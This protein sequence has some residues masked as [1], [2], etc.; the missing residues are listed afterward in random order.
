MERFMRS[1]NII[2]VYE[3]PLAEAEPLTACSAVSEAILINATPSP[4]ADQSVKASM[5]RAWKQF[6]AQV[7]RFCLVGGL[8][9]ILDLLLFNC[10]L[11]VFPTINPVNLVVYNSLAYAFG[12]INSFVLNKYWTFRHRQS[13]V[14]GEVARFII[15]TLV[16]ICVNDALLWLCSNSIHLQDINPTLWANVS[17]IVAIFGTFLISYAGMRL[18]VFS[19]RS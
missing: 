18:W 10:L 2:E 16:G 3:P 6:F 1:P 17:K 15:T 11:W 4:T 19:K 12:G 7:L 14:P 5:R 13:I 8:N 9:T